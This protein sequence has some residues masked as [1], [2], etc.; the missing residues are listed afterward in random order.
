MFVSHELH[1]QRTFSV[2]SMIPNNNNWLAVT[3]LSQ[4]RALAYGSRVTVN[5]IDGTKRTAVIGGDCSY[6][7]QSKPTAHIGLGNLTAN[8][9]FVEWPN[10]HTVRTYLHKWDVNKTLTISYHGVILNNTIELERITLIYQQTSSCLVL[11]CGNIYLLCILIL[12]HFH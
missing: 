8:K 5:L 12:I 11:K 4:K 2:F 9:L 10:G 3:P 7:C 6:M 1:N